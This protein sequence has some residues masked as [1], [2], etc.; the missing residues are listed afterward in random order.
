MLPGRRRARSAAG[1]LA[2]A[3]L[4]A[5]AGPVAADTPDPASWPQSPGNDAGIDTT[6]HS[7]RI[8]GPDRLQTSLSSALLLRGS[9]GYPFTTSD[10]TSGPG[11]TLAEA[12]GWWGLGTCPFSV[13]I[14][15]GDTAA[16]SL[17]AASL[18]DPTDQS[19][20]PFL[21]RSASRN[22][23]VAPV[24]EMSRVDTDSAP[25]VVTASARQGA[26]A[27]S[28]AA[29]QAI[30]DLADGGCDTVRSAIIVGGTSAVPAG[31]D[32]QLLGFRINEVFRVAGADRY[33]TAAAIARALGTGES[34]RNVA[35]CADPV[36]TDGDARM[37]FH[38]NAAIE[39]RSS[40]TQCR[41]LGRTVVLTDGITG[42]D[43]LAA[44][45]WTST[46]QVPVL[47]VD[48]DGNLPR[49]TV[50][51]LNSLVIDN[52]IVLGGRAR[53]PDA[54]VSQVREITGATTH[55]VAGTDR[56][57]TSVE[58]AGAFG[59]WFPTGDGANHDGSMVCLAASSGA[60]AASVGWP[61]ALGAGPWCARA[62]GLGS[63][64]AAPERGLPPVSGPHPRVSRGGQPSH[65]AVPVL[66]T[67]AGS[68]EL[69]GPAAELLAGTFDP[70]STW[71]T[72]LQASDSCLDPGF[73]VAFG[74]TAVLPDAAVLRAAQAVSGETYVSIDDQAPS[75][76]AGFWTELDL[77]P[78][79]AQ[80]GVDDAGAV[81]RVCVDRGALRGAR[82]LNAY[83]DLETTEFLAQQDV[84]LG[85]R[86]VTDRDGIARSFGS[87]SPTCV[88]VPEPAS[89]LVNGIVTSISG[90]TAEA[91][92]FVLADDRRFELSGPVEHGTA[93]AVGG[94]DPSETDTDGSTT[95][96]TYSDRDLDGILITSRGQLA[97][98]DAATIEITLVRAA[99]GDRP[100]R[101]TATLSL[102]TSLGTV[103]GTATG[104]ALFADGTWALRGRQ[105]LEDG[106]WNA[107]GG[108][109]GFSADLATDDTDP[110]ATS[111]AWIGDALL[112]ATQL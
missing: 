4:V 81:G 59:G 100:H 48:G 78:V 21:R 111:L 56:Y 80:G 64:T 31:V 70:A 10:R 24:G 52:V 86:Y 67:P 14:T 93:A 94:T 16:D 44:G 29:R 34:V 7:L 99:A 19:T 5:A 15:A 12:D 57:E 72:S 22:E 3:L 1:A 42:A 17:A 28:L 32:S 9:G 61:D 66:L 51:G 88:R 92:N 107:A 103:V 23:F 30:S 55:R 104:E 101:F 91:G 106:S 98:L 50:E 85:G 11:A 77:R 8:A 18:S 54:T 49:P 110:L 75:P 90:R 96:L 109:G 112:P 46:W 84:F 71:C 58:M 108:R 53:V 41:V 69:A 39:L 47:L 102:T 76:A 27:L 37:G 87:S 38:G 105:S 33:A 13:I 74:G 97:S 65:D 35:R 79:Y 82:W 63:A 6:A 89:S 25:I 20:E 73:V 62:G 60:G 40:P 26:T 95:V 45:W 36:V 83:A 43:A 68:G 2:V